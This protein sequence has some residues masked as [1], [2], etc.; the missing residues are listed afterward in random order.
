MNNRKILKSFGLGMCILASGYLLYLALF[1]ENINAQVVV[2]LVSAMAWWFVACAFLFSIIISGPVSY[3]LD[4]E[5]IDQ[6]ACL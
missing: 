5:D 1:K 6:E 4:K 2:C 3:D